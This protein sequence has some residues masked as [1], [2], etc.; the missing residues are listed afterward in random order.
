[1]LCLPPFSLLIKS[2]GKFS[3][4][5]AQGIAD[6][7]QI[8]E[9]KAAV[10]QFVFAYETLLPTQLASQVCLK[11]AGIFAGLTQQFQQ[12]LSGFCPPWVAFL[13]SR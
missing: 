13:H 4:G 10:A 8:K 12:R 5:N 9:V 7:R 3:E 2:L 1:M 6:I 11:D